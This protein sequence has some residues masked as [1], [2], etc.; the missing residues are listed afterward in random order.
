MKN[1]KKKIEVLKNAHGVAAKFISARLRDR[2]L[3]N[4]KQMFFDL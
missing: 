2:I 3:R 4:I 1:C